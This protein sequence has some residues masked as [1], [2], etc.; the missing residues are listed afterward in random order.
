MRCSGRWVR[1]CGTLTRSVTTFGGYVLDALGD[2]GGVLIL[3]DTGDLKKG[4]HTV[5]VQRQY[6]GTAGRD[7]NAQVAVFLAYA[8]PDGYVLID[9]EV[10]RPRRWSEDPARCAAAGVPAHVGFAT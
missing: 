8:A 1:R 7:E 4:C 2:P 10:Y 5:G 9:R 6:T 3:D